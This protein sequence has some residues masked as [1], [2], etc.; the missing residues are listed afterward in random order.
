[1]EAATAESLHLDPKTGGKVHSGDSGKLLKPFK[2]YPRDTRPLTR[3][4]S[5][6]S[7]QT[8]TTWQPIFK[9]MRFMGT[10]YSN[11]HNS[12]LGTCL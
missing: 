3:L 6:N 5:P 11:H 10:S 12:S 2:V 8:A 1:M 7:F 4:H 9:C